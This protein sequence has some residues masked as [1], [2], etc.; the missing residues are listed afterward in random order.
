MP[1]YASE[2]DSTELPM[3]MELPTDSALVPIACNGLPGS[4]GSSSEVTPSGT[5]DCAESP[6]LGAIA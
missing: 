6:G 3:P 4:F 1:E 5:G 2:L